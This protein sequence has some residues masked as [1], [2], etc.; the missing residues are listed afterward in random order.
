[1]KINLQKRK[2]VGR[3]AKELLQNGQLPG[4][5]YGPKRESLNVKVDANEFDKVYKKVGYGKIVELTIEGEKD[6]SKALIR[7][8]QL[9]PV[10]DV[11]IHASLFE[12]D[13]S[14]PITA[15]VQIVTK[16]KSKVVEEKT[17]FLV[18]PFESLEVRCL[19]NKLPAE[20]VIDISNLNE[21]GDSISVKALTFPEGVELTGDVS[22][23]ATLA[24]VAPP[25]KE[26]VEEEVKVEEV[27]EGA[28][29]EE[30]EGEEE[31]EEEGAEETKPSER[32]GK[33]E[34][35]GEGK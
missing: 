22:E 5:V 30:K 33:E 14:K 1:M 35:K 10:K 24:Y 15:E 3:K 34:I 19:P 29:E 31:G 13:L 17:G 12:L 18:T 26:I 27:E 4:V 8:V 28:E 7:E 2:I 11:I 6:V 23:T 9:D 25:Q 32:D 20:L 21:I 16:G